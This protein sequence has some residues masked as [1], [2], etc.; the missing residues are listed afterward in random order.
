MDLNS[1]FASGS[2]VIE[3]KHPNTGDILM[4]ESTPP[5]PMTLTVMGTHTNQYKAMSRKIGFANAKRNKKLNIDKLSIEE[6]V[7]IAEKND[8]SE[9]EI[10][11]GTVTDCNLF[12]DGKKVKF[13]NKVILDILSD[14]KTSWI[15][16]QLAEALEE[17]E[18]FFKG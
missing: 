17:T 18:L 16:P 10:K 4:D 12:M 14:E 5:Q 2:A 8:E 1:V 6:L 11:A 9:I 7:S 3:L 15:Y 13:S